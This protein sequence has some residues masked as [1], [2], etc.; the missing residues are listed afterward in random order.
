MNSFFNFV[1]GKINKEMEFAELGSN[2]DLMKIAIN[3]WQVKHAQKIRINQGDRE[4]CLGYTGEHITKLLN[5]RPLLS[6]IVKAKRG[7]RKQ[8]EGN[9]KES[10]KYKKLFPNSKCTFELL[11]NS[12]E[13]EYLLRKFH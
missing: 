5:Y 8:T 4:I 9:G 12:K 11:S 7:N 6:T 3:I 10:E 1:F 2:E 13:T